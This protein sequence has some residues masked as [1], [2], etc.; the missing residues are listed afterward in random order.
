MR[1]QPRDGLL[2]DVLRRCYA[3]TGRP[4]FITEASAKW[5]QRCFS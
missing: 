4:L 5:E 3:D 1:S 2:A